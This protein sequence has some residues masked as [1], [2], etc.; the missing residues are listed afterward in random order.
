MVALPK[1]SVAEDAR[2]RSVDEEDGSARRWQS[3][4]YHS[5]G[6]GTEEDPRNSIRRT[7]R[8]LQGSVAGI[9]QCDVRAR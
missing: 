6:C 9:L 3:C 1:P 7:R 5:A 2:D 4:P 8:P